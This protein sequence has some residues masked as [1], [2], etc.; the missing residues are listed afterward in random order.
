MIGRGSR[1]LPNKTNF[2]IIDLGNNTE[3]FG[4]WNAPLNWQEV[5]DHPEAFHEALHIHSGTDV[6][7]IPTE[8]RAKFPNSAAISFDIQEAHRNS[9]ASNKKPMIVMRDSIRQHALI[10]LENAGTIE[11]AL[12]L[13]SELDK[14]IDWRVKQYTKCLG[15]VTKNY[16]EWLQADYRSRLTTLI[17]KLMIR[18]EIKQKIA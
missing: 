3:R 8:L 9:V 13:A 11:E 2:T 17:R 15:N 5:F 1:R 14:E 18:F 10:C 6:H 4:E 16:R 7:A 12:A